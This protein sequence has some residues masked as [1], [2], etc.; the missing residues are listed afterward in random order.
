MEYPV[1]RSRTLPD[2]FAW[3]AEAKTLT[4]LQTSDTCPPIVSRTVYQ[5]VDRGGWLAPLP[6][7]KLTRIEKSEQV[8]CQPT[9]WKVYWEAAPWPPFEEQR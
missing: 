4:A 9:E 7:W 6:S 8:A 1:L 3:N 5:V 2:F